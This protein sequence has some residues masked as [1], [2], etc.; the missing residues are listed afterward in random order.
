MTIYSELAITR[1]SVTVSPRKAEAWESLL[2]TKGLS[3]KRR[4]Q[5]CPDSRLWPRGAVSKSRSR[6]TKG[7]IGAA[8]LAFSLVALTVKNLQCRRPEFD[9]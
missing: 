7:L 6:A 8:G 2:V 1:E 3:L 4:L 9:P 5:V